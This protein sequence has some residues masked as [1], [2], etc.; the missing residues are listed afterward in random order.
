MNNVMEQIKQDAFEDELQK[1][2]GPAAFAGRVYQ[3]AGQVSNDARDA[4]KRLPS[5]LKEFIKVKLEKTKKNFNG[6]RYGYKG[7]ELKEF[8]ERGTDNYPT[9]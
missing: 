8:V 1:M 7:R 4:L 9:F 6:G 3:H 5:Y 2:A